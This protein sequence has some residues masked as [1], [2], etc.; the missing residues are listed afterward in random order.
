MTASPVRRALCLGFGACAL[1]G[2]GAVDD[3]QL[4]RQQSLFVQEPG[5]PTAGVVLA[6]PNPTAAPPLAGFVLESHDI[7][8]QERGA[9]GQWVLKRGD[10]TVLMRV[11]VAR[12]DNAWARERLQHIATNT[13]MATSPFVPT[14][15]P[16]GT[17][18]LTTPR[19]RDGSLA[20]FY[21]NICGH[22]RGIDTPLDVA[23][24]ADWLQAR[25]ATG[26]VPDVTPH[27]PRPQRILIQPPAPARGQTVTLTVMVA[28]GKRPADYAF[29][30]VQDPKALDLEAEGE[31]RASFRAL[32]AGTTK[33]QVDMIDRATLVS[34]RVP[35]S[36]T[37]AP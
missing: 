31:D 3:P 25:M 29:D 18:S 2:A 11:F 16:I 4:M 17:H 5:A 33:V 10:Q 27:R 35:V 20:W 23:A 21:Y 22:I 12:E 6:W 37:I 36:L 24:L 8:H 19:S 30:F 28:D 9:E 13:S 15:R 32:A 1:R 34:V 14:S 7:R 26:L